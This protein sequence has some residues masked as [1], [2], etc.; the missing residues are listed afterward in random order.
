MPTPR[1]A[2]FSGEGSDVSRFPTLLEMWN[3]PFRKVKE[4]H[5]Q[6]ITVE[7]FDVLCLPPGYYQFK[8]SINDAITHFV[9]DGGGCVG[10]CCG[11]WN[12]ACSISLIP[13]TYN[14]IFMEGKVLLHPKRSDHPI[15]RD[16]VKPKPG[17]G[18]WE[19][20][21]MTHVNG[22]LFVPEDQDSVLATF[23]EKG[24]FAAILASEVGSGRVVAISSHAEIDIQVGECVVD[25]SPI[26]RDAFLWAANLR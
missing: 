4:E 20:L 8:E 9:H 18:G 19:W 6:R 12:I 25:N 23:D 24:E 1:V 22:A 15:L 10:A 17:D 5:L 16:H 2:L 14:Q 3:F 7:S 11:A 26:L 21:P 13:C